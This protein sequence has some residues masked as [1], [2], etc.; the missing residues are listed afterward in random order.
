M[1]CFYRHSTKNLVAAESVKRV[2]AGGN[3]NFFHRLR[4][5]QD[6]QADLRAETNV[7]SEKVAVEEVVEG[8][9]EDVSDEEWA[10]WESLVKEEA[11]DESDEW[12]RM[13]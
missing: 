11:V 6:L 9:D 10:W 2:E 7:A 13:G 4:S 12:S 5:R 8:E 3:D 1:Y